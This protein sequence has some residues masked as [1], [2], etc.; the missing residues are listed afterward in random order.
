MS[1]ESAIS[2]VVVFVLT[3]CFV[4]LAVAN[5]VQT[6]KCEAAAVRLGV[7]YVYSLRV[8]CWVKTKTGWALLNKASK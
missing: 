1:D 5:S 6:H 2:S 3:L 4:A 8:G 7:E